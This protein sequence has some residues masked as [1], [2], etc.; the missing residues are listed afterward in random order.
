MNNI[1]SIDLDIL[2]SPYIGIYNNMIN[3]FT[4]IELNWHIINDAYNLED[5][6][7][8]PLYI[9]LITKIINKYKDKKFYI[10]LNHS[11]ILTA[12]ENSKFFLQQPYKFNL[13]NIDYHHDIFYGDDQVKMLKQCNTA[14]C[15]NWVGFLN[16]NHFINIYYW[17]KGLGSF[18]NPTAL[19]ESYPE[20]IPEKIYTKIFDESTIDEL[21]DIDL[22][23][24]SISP[25][26]I[27]I[28][29][30]DTLFSI[31]D[32][33]PKDKIEYI[34]YPFFIGYEG[35]N[36]L[37]IKRESSFNEFTTYFKK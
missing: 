21:I 29:Y 30:Y 26:W 6:K 20:A 15:G 14:N 2:F 17:F 3:N 34:E 11:S 7:P 8:Y 10:G 32:N 23:F 35:R 31:L 16:Q 33:I 9:D 12:I 24:I 36:F 4:S 25:E 37:N 28:N 18:F 1:L 22:I 5:F 13:Y 19:Q 27:P